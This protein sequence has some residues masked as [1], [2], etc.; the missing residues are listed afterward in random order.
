MFFREK[1]EWA[2]ARG[3]VLPSDR[4]LKP[5]AIEFWLQANESWLKPT[6]PV[7]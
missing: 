4:W 1:P 2:K 7:S 6:V 5:T 3:R